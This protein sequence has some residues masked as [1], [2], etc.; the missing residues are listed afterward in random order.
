[1]ALEAID[2]DSDVWA[3]TFEKG[4][5]GED[6]AGLVLARKA[7]DDLGVTVG[8]TVTL[9]HPAR[10]GDGFAVVQTP[11][12]V[13][14]IHPEPVPVHRLH[15][16]HRSSTPSACRGWPTRPTCCRPPAPRPTTC[17]GSCSASPAWPRCSPWRCPPRSWR[18]ACKE[19]TG[20][21]QVLELFILVLAMLIAYNATSINADERARERATLFAFGMPVRRVLGLETA[22]GLLIGL[23]GTAV[24]VGVGLLLNRWIIASTMEHDHARHGHGHR[25][26]RQHRA[27]RRGAQRDRRRPSR[28]C[29][30]S[31]GSVAWTSPAPYAWSNSRLEILPA[32]MDLGFTV[33]R[34]GPRR[35]VRGR[36]RRERIAGIMYSRQ[37]VPSCSVDASIAG[38]PMPSADEIR[39]VQRATWAGLSAGWEKWDS[40]IMDQLGPVGAAMIERL[41]IAEDHQ[42]LDIAAGTGEPGLSIARLSP[43]G[44]VVLT[45]LVAE[46]LDI[47][48]RRARAQGIANVET[49]GVQRR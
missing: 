27:H 11:M 30:P 17:S 5:L 10:Q 14:A 20:I 16:P 38:G 7:A 36:A 1:M 47:A 15:R 18:T 13:A 49:T 48:A 2:L 33:I 12:R 39:D 34:R 21:F 28:R 40:V 44:R 41:D 9:E 35:R 19:F 3:P 32:S 24:G 25:R 45:D 31:A 37:G 4:G 46:M 6:R 22:E 26:V 42:H 43:K 29:S 23:L 8:D